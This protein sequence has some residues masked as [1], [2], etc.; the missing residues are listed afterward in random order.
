MASSLFIATVV[1][2]WI[3]DSCPTNA[4]SLSANDPAWARALN[5]MPLIDPEKD[6]VKGKW[7]VQ[8]GC[9]TSG[10]EKFERIQIPYEPPEEYDYRI[11]FS[12][13]QGNDAVVQFFSCAGHAVMWMMGGDNNRVFGFA[14]FGGKDAGHHSAAVRTA[15]CL[16]NG[17]NY[18]SILQVRRGGV[19]AYVDDRLVTHLNTDFSDATLHPLW[20]LPDHKL[21]G[22]GSWSSSIAFQKIEL[23]EITGKG[24]STRRSLGTAAQT[25]RPASAW[26]VTLLSKPLHIGD[27]VNKEMHNPRPDAQRFT[28]RFSLP[29]T[30]KP[31][32]VG[33]IYVTIEV[34]GLVP[35]NSRQYVALI[36]AGAFRT[37]LLINGTEVAVLN[38]LVSGKDSIAKIH[39]LQVRVP[40]G[41]LRA[42]ANDLEIVPGAA[43]KNLDD[44]ELHRVVV[45][46]SLQ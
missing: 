26:P 19:K 29:P 23:L 37:K 36:K 3:A 12:R 42:D 46:D 11:V 15:A 7:T 38:K 28:A 39:K 2:L 10:N 25:R 16:T 17:R 1:A 18:T 5:L 20:D 13:S 32:L 30:V 41:I 43:T 22:V 4:E 34:G 35:H 45:G 24:R 8:D 33:F 9:L 6:A 21:L 40:G 14:Y 27:D 44:F 31:A